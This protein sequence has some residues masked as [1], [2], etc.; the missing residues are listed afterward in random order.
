[1]QQT[2]NR[3]SQQ[4]TR[5]MCDETD[6]AILFYHVAHHIREVTLCMQSIYPKL[7]RAIHFRSGRLGLFCSTPSSTSVVYSCRDSNHHLHHTCNS[8]P[9]VLMRTFHRV[10]P[11]PCFGQDPND[12]GSLI[13]SELS[14]RLTSPSGDQPAQLRD[15]FTFPLKVV[16]TD[17][18]T[19]C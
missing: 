2:P 16:T 18:M 9:G 14:S 13:Q 11:L 17:T 4:G 19:L 12:E 7:A 1:M 3:E 5:C 15:A 6:W 10:S 8:I